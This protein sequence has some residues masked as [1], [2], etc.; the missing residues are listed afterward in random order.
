MAP[1]G[2]GAEVAGD[3]PASHRAGAGDRRAEGRRGDRERPTAQMGVPHHHV[4]RVGRPQ[5]VDENLAGRGGSGPQRLVGLAG[6]GQPEVG[7]VVH[8]RGHRER[9]VGQVGVGLVGRNARRVVQDTGAARLN[10]ARIDPHLDGERPRLTRPQGAQRAGTRVRRRRRRGARDS[11]GQERRS[12]G[13]DVDHHHVGRGVRAIVGY[14]DRV[15]ENFPGEDGVGAGGLGDRQVRGDARRESERSDVRLAEPLSRHVVGGIPERAVIHRVH[16][17]RAVVAPA[18]V[19]DEVASVDEDLFA[20]RH[21]AQGVGGQPSGVTDGRENR[22]AARDVVGEPDVAGLVHSDAAQPA[23]LPCGDGRVL[24]GERPLLEHR[25]AATVRPPQLEPADAGVVHAVHV[26][27][28][29]ADEGLV[30]AEVAVLE[31]PHRPLVDRIERRRCP[32]LGDA[33]EAE[34]AAQ[35]GVEG[36]QREVGGA[37]EA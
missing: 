33:R 27:D 30:G 23:V 26:D 29:V 4:S 34:E 36:R 10:H 11:A 16:V 28:E 9:V 5:V 37:A 8:D 20:L 35:G 6:F 24:R 13:K 32:G 7:A 21:Q 2:L 1:G 15:G 18:T 31:A 14:R 25:P 3:H 22:P 12:L 17:E 19:A